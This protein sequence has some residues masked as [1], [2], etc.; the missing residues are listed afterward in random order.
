MKK[1][2]FMKDAIIL[3]IITMLSG[4]M[5]GAVYEI[6]KEPIAI[7]KENEKKSAYK[8]VFPDATDFQK[9]DDD[10]LINVNESLP[11]QNFGKVNVSEVANAVDSSGSSLGYVIT[12]TSKDGFGGDVKI[13]VGITKDK[14]LN[15]IAFLTL[16][17]TPGLGMK[18]KGE[19]FSSQFKEKDASYLNVVK[20]GATKPDEIDAISGAT[21]TSRAVTGAVNAAIYYVDKEVN[22]E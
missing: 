6:T 21:I 3:F 17:E 13:S 9:Q 10:L 20:T 19:K 16:A 14:K 4:F 18:A 1:L 12:S 7:A 22:H 2:S 15:G 5:L 8:E 11:S